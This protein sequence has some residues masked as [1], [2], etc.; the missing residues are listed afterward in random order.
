MGLQDYLDQNKVSGSG[1]PLSTAFVPQGVGGISHMTLDKLSPFDG[2][3]FS[4]L[5]HAPDFQALMIAVQ[6][7]GIQTPLLVRPSATDIGR[8]EII[9]GHRRY[10]I[11]ELLELPTVP[12]TIHPCDN[13]TAIQLM[14]VSNVQRPDWLPSEKAKTYKAHLEATQRKSGITAGR[15]TAENNSP[16]R[17]ANYRNEDEAAKTWSISGETLRAYIKLNDLLPNLLQ[18]TD[19]GRIVVKGAYQLAFLPRDQQSIVDVILTRY[20]KKKLSAAKAKEIRELAKD[21]ELNELMVLRVLGIAQ[22][23]ASKDLS[24]GINFTSDSLLN[25]KTV[26][27]LLGEADVLLAIES[28]LIKQARDRSLPLK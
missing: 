2:H 17:L 11:A 13:D 21:D 25:K 20:P 4:V 15:P 19:E 7:H 3:T 18:Y 28:L 8:F 9:S 6:E 14:A 5:E 23:E 27:K 24:I 22:R 12:C 26:K 16:T 1:S 10:R